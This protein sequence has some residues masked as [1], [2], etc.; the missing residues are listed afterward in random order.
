M[1]VD[2]RVKRIVEF[3]FLMA[4][5]LVLSYLE[6]LIDLSSIL[7]GVKIGISNVVLTFVLYQYG[8]FATFGFGLSKSILSMFFLGRLSTLFYSLTGMVF[9][10][11]A[12]II[13][14]RL[15][16]FSPLGVSVGGAVMHVV[17]QMCAAVYVLGNVSVL[18][19]VPFLIITGVL[20]GIFTY[21]PLRA[22]WKISTHV[23][24]KF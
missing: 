1:P 7:P 13:I 19:F 22:L 23:H 14:H 5:A 16:V 24:Q 15:P 17:G 8:D 20:S 9:A 21:I 2:K 11:I 6:S 12:M 18:R 4:I 10:V 3:A